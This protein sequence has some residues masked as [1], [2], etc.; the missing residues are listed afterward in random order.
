[1][2][3]SLPK[4]LM[5]L[6]LLVLFLFET[7][8]HKNSSTLSP[9]GDNGLCIYTTDVNAHPEYLYHEFDVSDLQIKGDPLISYSDILAYDLDSHVLTLTMPR[10]SLAVEKKVQG[11]PFIVTLDGRKMYGGWFWTVLSSAV[12]NGVVIVLDDPGDHLQANQI[13]IRLGYPSEKFFKGKDPRNNQ[14]IIN[15]LY[16]DHKAH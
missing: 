5:L 4:F 13:R 3:K 10:D 14:Q 6:F 9:D 7:S 1:M 16:R 8:C 2:F 15:R 11:V 12:C